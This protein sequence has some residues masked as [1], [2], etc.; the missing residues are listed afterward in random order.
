MRKDIGVATAAYPMPALMIATYNENGSVDVMNMAWGGICGSKYIAMNLGERHKTVENLKARKAFTIGLP[1]VD[2][3]AEADYFGIASGNN[4]SDKFERSG[5]TAVKSGF[6]DAPIVEEFPVALECEVTEFQHDAAGFRV[7]GEI[8]NVSVDEK[9]LDENGK[10]DPVK[11]N[12]FAFDP[13]QHGYYA[14]GEKIGDA[15]G[16]G[17]KFMK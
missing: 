10:V 17:K 9:V 6:V 3:V 14:I 11:I 1:D 12:T 13:F 8:K 16:D 15:W 5:L 2:H 4:V 7:I